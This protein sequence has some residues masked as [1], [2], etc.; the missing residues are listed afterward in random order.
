MVSSYTKKR[1]EEQSPLNFHPIPAIIHSETEFN[2]S[3]FDQGDLR[4]TANK[5]RAESTTE[6][7]L[8]ESQ[9]S[10]FCAVL[11]TL[12]MSRSSPSW[13][14]LSSCEDGDAGCTSHLTGLLFG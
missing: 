12:G 10:F 8:S 3:F 4:A 14:L 1:E 9:T 13:I 5:R 2:I 11:S 6:D 7:K